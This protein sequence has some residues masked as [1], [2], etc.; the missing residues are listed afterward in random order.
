MVLANIVL[1]TK[2]KS[3]KNDPTRSY[4][5]S[6]EYVAVAKEFGNIKWTKM[7]RGIVKK[8]GKFRDRTSI[9]RKFKKIEIKTPD[10]KTYY[11]DNNTKTTRDLYALISKHSLH[12]FR[13]YFPPS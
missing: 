2:P 9:K 6:S 13:R 5:L 7:L 4:G 12:I 8:R 10:G 3:A 11:Q 1:N